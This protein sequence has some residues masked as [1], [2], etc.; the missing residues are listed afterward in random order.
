MAHLTDDKLRKLLQAYGEDVG[1]FTTNTRSLWEKRLSKLK[2][3]R[4]RKPISPESYV[5]D[6]EIGKVPPS[7]RQPYDR[8][9]HMRT[10]CLHLSAI[11]R[12]PVWKHPRTSMFAYVYLKRLDD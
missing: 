9:P 6:S 1:P 11:D 4:G 7:R 3:S 8:V 10:K 12:T 5:S 2:S